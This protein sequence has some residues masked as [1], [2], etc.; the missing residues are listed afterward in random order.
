MGHVNKAK[1][2]GDDDDPLE[3]NIQKTI[4]AELKHMK[5]ID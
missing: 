4:D 2:G 5:R 3:R 1:K